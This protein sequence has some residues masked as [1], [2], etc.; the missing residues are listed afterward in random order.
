MAARRPSSVCLACQPRQSIISRRRLRLTRSPIH[1]LE[2]VALRPED[3]GFVFGRDIEG[4]AKGAKLHGIDGGGGGPIRKP[5]KR[6]MHDDVE[7]E[8]LL[9]FEALYQTRD[10][11]LKV[12]RSLS[13]PWP[14]FPSKHN[15]TAAENPLPAPSPAITD[16]PTATSPSQSLPH[17]ALK[18]LIPPEASAGPIPHS[19]FR[20][21]IRLASGDKA[22]R[23]VLRAQL[24]RASH[25]H[26][27]LKIVATAMQLPILA[28]QLAI[29]SEPIMRALYRCRR[30][31]SDPA[32]LRCLTQILTRFRWAGVD[33]GPQLVQMG[34]KFAARSR[35][36]EAMRAYLR[37]YK[38]MGGGM[39]SNIF[40]S[41][42]AKFS[43]G[44][45]G[46][47]E[48]RNGRWKRRDLMQVLVGFEEEERLP[49]EE[50][51]HFG[52][53][54]QADDWQY[55]HGWIAVL[56]RCKA[57]EV[58]WGEWQAW[59]QSEARLR[60]KRL[61]SIGSHV[62][63]KVRGDYWFLEQMTYTGDLQRAWQLFSEADLEFSKV[64]PKVRDK[65]LDG[66]QHATLWTE[67]VR[68]AMVQKW[69][70][71]LASIEGAL[72]VR[73][74]SDERGEDG[75]GRHVL[76]GNQEEAL[77]KLAAQPETEYGFPYA[78]SPIVSEQDKELH[79]AAEAGEAA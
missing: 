46:L 39:S 12:L 21:N 17:A 59:K 1:R 73:W 11:R 31:V 3:D 67:D 8:S 22:I 38:D 51:C 14:M 47:G 68:A 54:L 28:G 53:F 30:N 32:V 20:R 40:R 74:E 78:D 57:D 10:V 55:L 24:L 76:I 48:I 69:D 58:I 66:V 41:V 65:L 7:R 50:K 4:R 64:K 77:A 75:E 70:N 36:K 15:K 61:A 49:E 26:E 62:T 45:R 6:Q 37:M 71:D 79:S 9:S 2:A 72:G 43:I 16:I 33:G 34:L 63:S 52:T 35:Q 27:I 5:A 29:L 19:D 42:I 25:P 60:P 23:S 18:R 13:N 44:H 56:A